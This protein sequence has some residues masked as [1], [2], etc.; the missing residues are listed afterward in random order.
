MSVL[1][2]GY[3]F[4]G[5]ADRMDRDHFIAIHTDSIVKKAFTTANHKVVYKLINE[6]WKKWKENH[7]NE[8]SQE[9][10]SSDQAELMV[11]NSEKNGEHHE[12]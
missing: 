6:L 5:D 12:H 10:K 8:V 4:A 11:Q 2:W 3:W 9:E 1:R 7:P